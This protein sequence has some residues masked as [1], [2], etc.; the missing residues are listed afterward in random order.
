MEHVISADG[1]PIA[2]E[3]S[4]TGPPLVLVHGTSSAGA[5]WAPNLPAFEER[6]TVF[7]VDRRGR[8]ASGDAVDYAIEREFEDV[9]AIVDVVG[10]PVSLLGHSFGALCVLE[11]ALLTSNISKLILYEPYM[12]ISDPP[13]YDREVL[14]RFQRLL[15]AGDRESVATGMFR[16]MLGMSEDELDELRALPTW[17]M[18]VESAHTIVR[19]T[20]AELDYRFAAE[21]FAN[22]R[23][24]T[25]LLLG[26]DTPPA[27]AQITHE[28]A[29]SLPD[30]R[31]AVMPGQGHMA[32]MTAP[33][34]F[35]GTV[36]AFLEAPAHV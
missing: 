17:P 8:G 36:L 29:A 18:R 19:E 24:P 12:P 20:Q 9:A 27:L 15:D 23:V 32:M 3:R 16:D 26:S 21:R 34:L 1:T 35:V 5:R 25:L 22:L 10:E 11:A 2:Y 6:F 28:V 14:D 7:T 4:G 31:I 33:E 30:S 13:L